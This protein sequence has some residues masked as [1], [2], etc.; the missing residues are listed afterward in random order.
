MEKEYEC[1]YL[2]CKLKVSLKENPIVPLRC[3]HYICMNYI[4]NNLN[5]EE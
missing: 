4:I 2:E 3:N 1:E 5:I